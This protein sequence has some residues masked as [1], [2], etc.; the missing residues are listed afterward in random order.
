[1][2]AKGDER[3][4]SEL[5][6]SFGSYWNTQSAAPGCLVAQ[7]RKLIAHT[8]STT[9]GSSGGAIVLAKNPQLVVGIRMY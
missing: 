4:L 7:N 9:Q 8:C 6:D 1:M 2:Y 5:A 3:T